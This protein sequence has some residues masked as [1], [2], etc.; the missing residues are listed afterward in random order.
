MFWQRIT[1]FDPCCS[2]EIEKI[3]SVYKVGAISNG[4]TYAIANKQNK[5]AK[6][7]SSPVYMIGH[8]KIKKP[9]VGNPNM[10]KMTGNS[11]N[12]KHQYIS[13]K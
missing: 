3:L 12:D 8:F 9:K 7:Q 11:F 2:H 1:N 6:E 5:S 10:Y 13:A 4:Y